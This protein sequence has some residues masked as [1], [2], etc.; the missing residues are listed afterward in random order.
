M[1]PSFNNLNPE[2]WNSSG[3]STDAVASKTFMS[4]VFG[5]MFGALAITAL[6]SYAFGNIPE[7]M[8]MLYKFKGG[9]IIGFHTLGVVFMIAPIILVLVMNMAFERLSF[10]ALVGCFILFSLVFGASL[11]TIF[12]R[13]NMPTIGITF[14]IAAG[15]FGIMSV[16]GYITKADLTSFGAILRMALFGMIIAMVV[17][18][19]M[20]S[21]MMQYVISLI[22]VA[23]FT[24]L[25]AYDVQKLKQIGAGITYSNE[26]AAKLSIMG[27]MTLY[28]DFIN[29]FMF[30]L[31]LMGGGNRR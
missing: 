8:D 26:S 19:F 20:K 23:V 7:L 5:W 21:E 15:M 30:L 22:G 3:V 16:M 31:R 10:F 9:R 12:F 24:G 4:S 17:N 25:T 29:L 2:Q 13:Y 18:F 1:K 27:A 28:L 14:V 6:M 11:S